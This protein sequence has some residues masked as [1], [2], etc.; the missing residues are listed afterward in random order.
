MIHEFFTLYEDLGIEGTPSFLDEYRAL[1][2][3]L[4]KR[5]SVL[6]GGRRRGGV[7]I[8]IDDDARLEVA[9]RHGDILHLS[10]GAELYDKKQVR[11]AA[12]FKKWRDGQAKRHGA[13]VPTD[14][15][16]N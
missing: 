3:L 11:L 9:L 5:V 2:L 7:A 4:G 12:R 16:E 14:G 10:S 13:Q 15:A 8:S 1:S 6:R